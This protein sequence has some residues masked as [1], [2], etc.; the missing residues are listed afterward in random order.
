MRREPH[1]R[2]REGPG[3]KFPRATRLVL[4]FQYEDDARSLRRQL[5][6]RLQRFHLELHPE[7]T[8]LFRF[9]K[10][11]RRNQS[12]RGLRKPTSFEFLGFTHICGKSKAGGFVLTRHSSKHRMRAK[13]QTV[14]VALRRR[15]HLRVRDQAVWLASVV[16]GFFAYHAVPTNIHALAS[17]RVQAVRH[18][19]QAL[20]RRGQRR[21]IN[22][23][24]MR[25]IADRWLPRARILHP[26]PERRFDERTRGRSRVR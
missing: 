14:K 26:W 8:R 19:I 23:T 12:E 22:W 3:V 10:N 24:Q 4:G 11:A 15:M 1:V 2:F 13:L 6:D 17:F 16:R 5:E 21:R 20:R 9:G 25:A 7:K 18:W